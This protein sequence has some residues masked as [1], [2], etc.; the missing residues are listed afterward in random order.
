MSTMRE[1]L[2]DAL[3]AADALGVG[4]QVKIEANAMELR[5]YLSEHPKWTSITLARGTEAYSNSNQTVWVIKR[6]NSPFMIGREY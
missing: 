1:R 3:A 5:R 2:V 4:R 6:G